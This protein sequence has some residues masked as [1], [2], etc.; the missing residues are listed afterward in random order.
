MRYVQTPITS[1]TCWWESRWISSEVAFQQELITIYET[2]RAGARA[3]LWAEYQVSTASRLLGLFLFGTMWEA[4]FGC[5]SALSSWL[6]SP[7]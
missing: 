5:R 4:D 7:F 3:F 2:I 1:R 6:V